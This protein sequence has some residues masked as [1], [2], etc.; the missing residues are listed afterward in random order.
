MKYL[1]A[2][3]ACLCISLPV[4]AQT[5]EEVARWVFD[6]T[7]IEFPE[8]FGV[9]YYEAEEWREFVLREMGDIRAEAATNKLDFLEHKLVMHMGPDSYTDYHLM[10][11]TLHYL[12][13]QLHKNSMT[14]AMHSEGVIY[15]MVSLILCSNPRYKEWKSEFEEGW[16]LMPLKYMC[17]RGYVV[18]RY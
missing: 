5:P 13:S 3:L 8:M 11:E 10:H 9:V 15:P 6:Q 2:F 7:I 4:E 18:S 14:Q 17:D 12:L 16:L 1:V